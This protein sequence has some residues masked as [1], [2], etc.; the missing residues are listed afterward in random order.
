MRRGRAGDPPPHPAR[1][2]I[3][4]AIDDDSLASLSQFEGQDAGMRVAV[5]TARRR[6]AGI[7]Q[8]QALSALQALKARMRR[9]RRRRPARLRAS[10]REVD[11]HP[12]FLD[13]IVEQ[14]K[15]AVAMAKK[16]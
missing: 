16:A 5:E 13:R 4:A 15:A 7:D 12:V 1:T 3:A 9:L 10:Q 14:R 8:H 6:L 11:E 2:A